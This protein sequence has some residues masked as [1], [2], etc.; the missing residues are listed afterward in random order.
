MNR[1]LPKIIFHACYG[2]REKKCRILGAKA[3]RIDISSTFGSHNRPEKLYT[4]HENEMS[5]WRKWL[6][7]HMNYE[8]W[9]FRFPNEMR[10]SKN[11]CHVLERCESKY[12]RSESRIHDAKVSDSGEST[13]VYCDQNWTGTMRRCSRN[14]NI[15]IRYVLLPNDFMHSVDVIRCVL[16]YYHKFIYFLG[17]GAAAPLTPAHFGN[18]W[19]VSI[20]E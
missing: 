15:E 3:P 7:Y 20:R 8:N 16:L 11:A 13:Y 4:S 9:N 6:L 10:K 17:K 1:R 12:R 14:K 5:L 19:D 2:S 18:I